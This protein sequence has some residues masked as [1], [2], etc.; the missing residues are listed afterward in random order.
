MAAIIEEYNKNWNS[1]IPVPLQLSIISES[2]G[3]AASLMALL[4]LYDECQPT[5][6]DWRLTLQTHYELFMNGI[7]K[8]ITHDLDSDIK[9]CDHVRDLTLNGNEP[10]NI[11]LLHLK[12]L[13]KALLYI[14]VLTILHNGDSYM[15]KFTS[16]L[17]LRVCV[18]AISPPI[19]MVM[20]HA[21]IDSKKIFLLHPT[22][23]R[24]QQ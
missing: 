13:D 17:I 3:H 2:G 8:K 11:D 20:P 1:P 12:K 4:R 24:Y 23:T 19:A 15:M 18:A 16:N 6:K 22:P 21:S 14:G 9:L 5:I 10:W 7:Q